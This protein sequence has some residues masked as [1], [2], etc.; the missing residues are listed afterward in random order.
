M[1]EFLVI[2]VKMVCEQSKRYPEDKGLK[3]N[4]ISNLLIFIYISL[5]FRRISNNI[6]KLGNN[7]IY[8]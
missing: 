6:F 7:C 5:P 4:D 2:N 8:L 3:L 1:V